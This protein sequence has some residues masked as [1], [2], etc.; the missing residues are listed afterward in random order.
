VVIAAIPIRISRRTVA[1]HLAA[2]YGVCILESASFAGKDGS[3][4]P[5]S[6]DSASG[7]GEP[8]STGV[9]KR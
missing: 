6:V 2:D 9:M 5:S 4:W 8:F 3:R 1:L 7:C